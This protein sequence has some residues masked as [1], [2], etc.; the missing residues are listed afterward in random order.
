[1]KIA[2][3]KQ[4]VSKDLYVCA[5]RSKLDELLFSSEG[6]VGMFSLFSLFDADFLYCGRRKILQSAICGKKLYL[7]WRKS[8]SA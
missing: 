3:V 5:N 6:R 4:D 8:M 1:M 7:I 2:L